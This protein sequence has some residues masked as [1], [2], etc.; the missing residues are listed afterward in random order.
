MADP[1]YG[2]PPDVFVAYQSLRKAREGARYYMQE[3]NA[4]D[5][6]RDL[7]NGDLGK[8]MAFAGL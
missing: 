1:K 7:L 3:F 8:V 5:V 2:V 6:E 4:D